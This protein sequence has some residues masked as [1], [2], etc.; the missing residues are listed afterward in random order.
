MK[1]FAVIPAF[2]EAPRI[3]QTV[4][5]VKPYVN[6]LVVVDDGSTDGTGDVARSAGATVV[7]HALNR[8]QGA[9]LRTGTE[10]ALQ[11]GADVIV[12]L[13]ADGQHDPTYITALV[14]PIVDGRCDVVLGSRFLGVKPEGMPFT[15]RCLLLAGRSFNAFVMGIPRKVTDPQ[16]G[17]RAMTASA[18]R[19]ID[20]KQNRMA[21]ASEMLRLVTRSDL[22]WA[23][24]PIRVLYSEETLAK[25]QFG[26]GPLRI[27]WQLF[28]GIFAD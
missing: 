4:Q 11:L 13:D 12:H 8:G 3:T 17:A 20:F 26:G 7:R 24:V 16:S 15:R 14:S 25:G 6:G 22:R 5:R 10:A 21:H 18:A 9:G 28:L 19:K 1:V 23:E 2:N 27:V